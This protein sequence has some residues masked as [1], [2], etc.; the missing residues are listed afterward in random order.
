MSPANADHCRSNIPSSPAVDDLLV[1]RAAWQGRFP[2][3]KS[4]CHFGVQLCRRPSLA[5]RSANRAADRLSQQSRGS[6][7]ML[8]RDY[9]PG[10]VGAEG[11]TEPPLMQS[12]MK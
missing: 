2:E 9:W 6:V 10:G 1:F 12:I 11:G 4:G 5:L 3:E 8:S 7:L